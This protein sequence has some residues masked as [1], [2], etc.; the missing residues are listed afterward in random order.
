MT[1]LRIASHE[2]Y[3]DAN[4]VNGWRLLGNTLRIGVFEDEL[5]FQHFVGGVW[6]DIEGIGVSDGEPTEINTIAVPS[7]TEPTPVHVN[8]TEY[9]TIVLVLENDVEL[10]FQPLSAQHPIEKHL[11]IVQG[12]SDHHH[13]SIPAPEPGQAMLYGRGGLVYRSGNVGSQDELALL[14]DSERFIVGPD[15]THLRPASDLGFGVYMAGT[16]GSPVTTAD[17]ADYTTGTTSYVAA[18]NASQARWLLA[19]AGNNS[20]GIYMCGRL[21]LTTNSVTRADKADYVAESTSYV[22]AYNASQAR[23]G[24][25]AAGNA[26][27]GIYMAGNTDVVVTTA[28]KADYI[29]ESTA[30]ATAYNAS[31]ARS[32]LA[33]ASNATPSST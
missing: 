16:T 28:D 1:D 6:I 2:V 20:F 8:F 10:T 5:K 29:A 19:A 17:R 25:A 22:A 24:L 15:Q 4:L 26:S 11:I 7:D 18:Y 21:G 31:Q 23:Q 27:F 3:G 30:A 13:V 9:R 14:W 33:A 12:D 32:G